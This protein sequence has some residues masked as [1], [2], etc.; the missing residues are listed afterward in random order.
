MARHVRSD[1]EMDRVRRTQELRRSSAATAIGDCKYNRNTKYP[2]A[3][4]VADADRDDSVPF[5]QGWFDR[6][7]VDEDS[8]ELS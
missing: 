4:E 1:E 8:G 7:P 5:V 3:M 6:E 2:L